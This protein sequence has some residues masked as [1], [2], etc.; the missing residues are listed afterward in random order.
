MF[1]ALRRNPGSYG[2]IVDDHF[3]SDFATLKWPHF[4]H[5]IDRSAYPVCEADG[6]GDGQETQGG[7]IRRDQAGTCAWSWFDSR[8]REEAGRASANGA[9]SA[10]EC[11][12][13]EAQTGGAEQAQV[14]SS[15]GVH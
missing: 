2:P 4:D 11:D 5:Y 14:E 6:E 7:A 1:L 15:D 3:L 13:A 12:S 9:T 8:G 10:G